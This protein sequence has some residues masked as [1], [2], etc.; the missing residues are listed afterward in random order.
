[1][2][3]LTI[4]DAIFM[5]ILLSFMHGRQPMVDAACVTL[6]FALFVTTALAVRLLLHL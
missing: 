3:A 5:P 2:V 1:V 4:L 6:I